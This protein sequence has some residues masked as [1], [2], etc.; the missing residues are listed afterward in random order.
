M[1]ENYA[2]LEQAIEH[3]E[4]VTAMYDG[5]RR[6]FCPHALGTK[7][8]TKHVLGYQFEGGS[9]HGLPPGGEWRCFAVDRLLNVTTCPG[10]WHTAAN[11]F[12]PQSCLDTIDLV[13][14]PAPP[15]AAR[16]W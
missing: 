4:H 6:A 9:V 11:I 2:L 14:Q 12:N 8:C 1:T 15:R 3:H 5:E 7:D 13:V 10:P 16:S